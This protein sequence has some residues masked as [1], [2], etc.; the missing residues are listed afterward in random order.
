MAGSIIICGSAIPQVVKTYKT[1]QAG[2]LSIAYL[3][4]LMLGLALLQAYCLHVGD[5]IFIIGNSCSLLM[6]G[7]LIFFWFAFRKRASGMRRASQSR[8]AGKAVALLQRRQKHSENFQAA[9]I[10]SWAR[11]FAAYKSAARM[12]SWQMKG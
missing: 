12:S 8:G 11:R 9:N 10:S 2:D 1:R 5:L 6:T 3:I 7:A 4:T